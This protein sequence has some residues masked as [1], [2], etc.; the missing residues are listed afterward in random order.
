[1]RW[2]ILVAVLAGASAALLFPVGSRASEAVYEVWITAPTGYQFQ[3]VQLNCGWHGQCGYSSGMGLDWNPTDT[4]AGYLRGGFK[5]SS[6]SLANNHLLKDQ[7]NI[8]TDP[9][10]QC[11]EVAADVWETPPIP[12]ANNLRFGMHHVHV[13]LGP[14]GHIYGGIWTSADNTGYFGSYLV[15]AALLD[16]DAGCAWTGPHIHDLAYLGTLPGYSTQPG[17]PTGDYCDPSIPLGQPGSCQVWW[18]WAMMRYFAWW[19]VE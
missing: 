3:E 9:G 14:A 5:R 2:L 18:N 6:G 11:D 12:Y 4:T 13:G 10:N 16:D 8:T 17:V 7:Y 15:T 1:M 19:S